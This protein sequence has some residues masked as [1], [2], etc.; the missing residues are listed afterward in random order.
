MRKRNTKVLIIVTSFYT[1]LL[2]PFNSSPYTNEVL[3]E[4][5]LLLVE[6]IPQF[7]EFFELEIQTF[8]HWEKHST[9]MI[10]PGYLLS[11][12]HKKNKK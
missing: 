11:D 9:I 4:V 2:Q 12:R 1:Y 10:Y 5:R 8:L 7:N 6:N 3:T